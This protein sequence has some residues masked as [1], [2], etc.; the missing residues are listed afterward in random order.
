MA[1][2]RRTSSGAGEASNSTTTGKSKKVKRSDDHPLKESN[3]SAKISPD[4][5]R[6]SA[7]KDGHKKKKNE[8]TNG[9]DQIKT[10]KIKQPAPPPLPTST[11]EEVDF[12]RGGGIRLTAYEQ[13]EAKRDGAREA[14]QQLQA[15]DQTKSRPKKRT[16]SE[17]QT[18]PSIKEKG[19][20]RAQ[21]DPPSNHI[22]DAHRIEHL[23]HKR[24]IPGIKLAG[25]IIQ[26]RPLELIIALPGQLVGHVPITDISS[27][28]TERLKET[29]EE[30]DES[31]DSDDCDSDQTENPLQGLDAMFTVGQWIR[32]SVVKATAHLPSNLR[33]PPL[34]RSAL[35]ITLT[36]DPVR[37]NSGIDKSD[38]EG[39]MTLTGAIKSIEDRGYI[40][41][42][43]ISVDPNIDAATSQSPVNNLTA[44]V[45]FTDADKATGINHGRQPSQQWEVGQVIWCRINKLS[46]NGAT[47]IVSV[48]PEDIS[49]S[50][51]TAVTNIDS[52][53]PLHM[54]SCQVTSVIPGQGLNVSFLGFFKGTIHL[55]YL[56]CHTTTADALGDRFKLGQKLRARVL[57]DTT[58]SKNHIS[59]EGNDSILEPK[60]FSLCFFDHVIKFYSPGLPPHLCSQEFTKGDRIDQLLRYP[61]GYVFQNV[62]IFRVDEEWG[63]YVTCV[64]SA[65]GL[66]IETEPPVAFAHI[67]SISDSF[68]ASLSQDSGPYK[69]GTTHKA[70]VTGVSPIDGILQL[71]L[72]QSVIEQP[73]ISSGDIPIGALVSGTVNKLTP[74]NLIIRIEG[75]IDAVV[76]P[77]H[78]SDVKHRNPE[79]KFIPGAKVKAR[80]LYTNPEKDQVV[81]TLRKTLVRS[82]SI[83]TSFE[84]AQVGTCT[85]GM[86]VKV[87]E[88]FMLVEFFG[89]TKAG[90]PIHEADTERIQSMKLLFKPENLVQVK[91]TK[92]DAEN[93]RI[94]ASVKLAKSDA[95]VKVPAK[96]EVGDKVTAFVRETG[97]NSIRLD[98]RPF[99]AESSTRKL[100]Q[101]LIKLDILAKKYGLSPEDLTAKLEKGDEVKDLVVKKKDENKNLLIVG[102]EPT[103]KPKAQDKLSGTVGFIHDKTLVLNLRKESQSSIENYVEGFLPIDLLAKHRNVAS[104]TLK[105]QISV[106]DVI[107]GLLPI[108]KDPLRGLLIVGYP[109]SEATESIEEYSY[110]PP[111]LESLSISDRVVG[112]VFKILDKSIILSLRKEGTEG[113]AKNMGVLTHEKLAKNRK[114]SEEQLRS[115]LKIGDYIYNLYVRKKPE[116]AVRRKPGENDC[117]YL[118]FVATPDKGISPVELHVGDHVIGTVDAIHEKN[119]VLSLQKEGSENNGADVL[120]QGIISLQVLSGHWKVHQKNLKQKLTEGQKIHKL[121]IKKTNTDKGLVIVGF[122]SAPH[123]PLPPSTHD[124][125]IGSMLK[126]CIGNRDAQGLKVTPIGTSPSGERFL[127][128]YTDMTDDYDEPHNYEAGSEVTACV[129]KVD[130]K[131]LTVYLSVRPS[132]LNKSAPEPTKN[133]VKD[134]PIRQFQDIRI[135][136]T[137]RGFVQK[138]SEMG[139]ILQVGTNIRA[140]VKVPELFDDDVPDWRSKFRV[141]QVVSGKVMSNQLNKLKL[142]LRKNAGLPKGVLTWNQVQSGQMILTQVRRIAS[143]G[144]FL[145]VPKSAISGLCHR[146]EIYDSKEQFAKH[147]DD[148]SNAYTEGMEL[149]AS[150][151][152]VDVENKKIS[153]TIKPSVVNPEGKTEIRTQHSEVVELTSDE[154][155]DD[156]TDEADS[157]QQQDSPPGSSSKKADATHK[158]TNPSTVSI[159]FAEP[160]LPLS[161]GFDWD[162][163]RPGNGR[164]DKAASAEDEDEG[165]TDSDDSSEGA[166]AVPAEEQSVDELEKLL[167]ES[168]NSSHLWNR[169][170]SLY[171]QKADIPQARQTARRA[172]EAIHYREEGE[173]WKVWIALLNLEN[174]YG[175]PEDFSKTFNE[176][177]V[178]NDSKTVWLKVADIYAQSGK[179]EKADETY[180]QAVKKFRDSSKAWTLYGE[181]CLRND[182][183]SQA[184]ELLSRSLKS[185][186][187]HKHVK[188]ISKFTQL[189]YKLG[190]PERGRTL[191]EGLVATFPKRL[192][193]WNVYVD[194]ETKAGTAAEVVRGL[195]SRILALKFN[196][197]RMKSIFKKWLSFEQAHGDKESQ[198][199]VIQKAQAYVATLMNSSN[200]LTHQTE[201]DRSDH[202]DDDGDAH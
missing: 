61:I 164:S 127:I 59:L 160:S 121:V 109:K 94:S 3:V 21:D 123:L 197:K 134:L 177:S 113:Y 55:P 71:T 131:S 188:T 159:D 141:A 93:R 74:T 88:K 43:G 81:L 22:T 199:M 167:T 95:P 44:F 40:V 20:K 165:S 116:Q 13:A 101:G 96:I 195:F 153:F 183:P 1:N 196:A 90:V 168:P 173:K 135:G 98:L 69:V 158:K 10:E 176:A 174:T 56:R 128:D 46:E 75:G 115:D 117:Y 110:T 172:L 125:A 97:Q 27:Y 185:L 4:K 163:K 92:I 192:D 186:P 142:S 102:F 152:S 118:G 42:L 23:N 70:R 179:T 2:K 65:D 201:A 171:I 12:P 87:E 15:L 16:L 194:L 84:S 119:V 86:I 17:S 52:I 104:D 151:I 155:D 144:M 19:K 175:T 202:G 60:I 14:E 79:K 139:L 105:T 130:K 31:E 103:L 133:A 180:G 108:H 138:I 82:D 25:M 32:C 187:K 193:L 41:D 57:W 66:P 26:V 45:S 77:A 34:V 147:Q 29:V 148:W 30:D 48:N 91:I 54:V 140:S 132:D 149:R 78:Y 49:R 129:V 189:E 68:L 35:K 18:G 33:V 126:V 6:N 154:S 200:P 136:S 8:T 124:L 89:R 198:D 120:I 37:V 161:K 170:I 38:L 51:L 112:R 143:Y 99:G 114:I 122:I 58:P 76:W 106:G 5:K 53:L 80:V 36:L 111:E 178:S 162:A 145:Q 100:L 50:V 83:V 107:S 191:F 166:S 190:D 137:V 72:R 150:V 182:R 62:R 7:A 184:G 146:S 39:G 181:F 47:C 63:V 64:N 156:E 11:A 67:A 85:Y 169:L 24:I 28:Y 73:F 157:I 9:K